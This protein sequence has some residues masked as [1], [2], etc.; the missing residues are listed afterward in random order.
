MLYTL[1]GWLEVTLIIE[2]YLLYALIDPGVI[3]EERFRVS[4]LCLG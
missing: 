4:K 2:Y 3:K 1:R